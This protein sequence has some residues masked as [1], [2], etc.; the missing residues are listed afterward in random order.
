MSTA[1]PIA[2]SSRQVTR[3]ATAGQTVFTFDAG[4]VWDVL[5]LVV[6]RKIAPATRFTTITSGFTLALLSGGVSGA[7]CT[8]AAAPRPTSGDPS[9]E[10]RITSR[11]VHE[12]QTDVSRSGRLHTP[13]M[14]T[15]FDKGTTTLQ[16][17]RRDIDQNDADLR[18]D[19]AGAVLGTIPDGTLTNPK[20]A[21]M[22][23]GTVKANLD[24]AAGPPTDAT[25][26]A[27]TAQLPAFAGDAGSG[28]VKG[29][30]PAPEAGDAASGKVLGAGGG[31]VTQSGGGAA[32][33]V[34]GYLTGGASNEATQ[35]QSA[36]D[37]AA[38][39]RLPLD[40][41]GL[42]IRVDSSINLPSHTTVQNGTIDFR[43][44]T[45]G[46]V[47]FET[48]GSDGTSQSIGSLS[49][50][51]ASAAVTTGSAF[52]AK[53]LVWISSA[54]V[55]GFS[56][57]TKGEWQRVRTVVS[58][59]L[60]LYGRLRDSYAT[61]V[62]IFKPTMKENIVIRNVRFL[63]GGD[64]Q[65]AIAISLR[66]LVN[67][68]VQ[69]CVFDDFGDR[70]VEVRRALYGRC[71]G[72]VMRFSN[73]DVGLSY[74]VALVNGCEAITVE[75]NTGE[76]LRHGVTVGGEDGVDRYIA[77]TNNAFTRMSDSG[78][79]THPNT[80]HVV[81]N[82]NVLDAGH[83]STDPDALRH[84]ITCQGAHSIV[85]DNIVSNFSAI[86][87]H[88]QPLTSAA[89]DTMSCTGNIVTSYE[90]NAIGIFFDGQK[91]SGSMRGLNISGNTIRL[92]STGTSGINVEASTAGSTVD[93]VSIS[94]NRV[95]VRLY[96]VR[97]LA[98]ASRILQDTT[99]TGNSLR[100]IDTSQ[101]V[102][103]LSN[104]TSGAFLTCVSV[105][106]NT[107]RGGT[108]GVRS[109][110]GA[111]VADRVLVTGNIIQGFATAATS[112]TMTSANNITT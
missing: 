73:E 69:N 77:I 38:A 20:F 101:A 93:G 18:A 37:A 80:S 90:T 88:L 100:C 3:T 92:P 89:D 91:I 21:A 53:D 112:G 16:E 85:S 12:R 41:E 49:E 32:I 4:P 59:T 65:A 27:L 106:G 29:L 94:A 25:L 78:I 39:A 97:L 52:A 61:T 104:T 31:W 7:S 108:H 98:A 36:V 26:A 60:N 24:G 96:A 5:D 110:S 40:L 82:G 75:G 95:Y 102:V 67:F 103:Q 19:L 84:G 79:D 68:I 44:A 51:A 8:F 30:V 17:L 72:N 9:V 1:I 76:D 107:I 86:G 87:I 45:T 35:L 13:S 56:A 6:Q 63:G 66:Y 14:E 50:G 46:D 10:I 28:G 15:E 81:I 71:G 43:N 105:T 64:A 55:F 23:A 42:T 34:T 109:D 54:D 99:I 58:N 70:C 83:F 74:G 57:S 48:G 33:L 11:R 111:N 2:R 22:P 62:R 47:A